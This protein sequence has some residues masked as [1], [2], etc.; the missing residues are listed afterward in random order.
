MADN[1]AALRCK[2]EGNKAL[3]RGDLQAAI[4][5]FTEGLQYDPT[6]AV[7]YSNRA[8]AYSNAGNWSQALADGEKAVEY[9][10][11]WGKAYNRK[12]LALAQLGRYEEAI[13]TCE[14]GLKHDPTNELLTS[15]MAKAKDGVM[16][17]EQNVLA[18]ENLAK[19]KHRNALACLDKA[20]ELCPNSAL[21][22]SNRTTA[23]LGCGL[24]AEAEDNARKVI[25][26]KP[27][28]H[29][30]YQRM[31]EVK[32]YQRNYEEACRWYAAAMNLKPDDPKLVSAFSR[33]QQDLTMENTRKR[34]ENDKAGE[35]EGGESGKE[36]GAAGKEEA[37]S[38]E[39]E[40]PKKKSSRF[41]FL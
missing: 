19:G 6:N 32:Q 25:A 37:T 31:A 17:S 1:N 34:A 5:H 10:P 28:W 30:G 14:E 26:L 21:F 40:T 2:E 18:E 15:N 35:E 27:Q 4:T 41:G 22:W 16:A 38:K 9:R 29:R 3:G 20:V 23:A 12:A 8:A 36:S 33:A 7:L 39:S 11:D 24:S 13:A